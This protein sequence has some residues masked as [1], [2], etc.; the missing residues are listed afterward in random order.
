VSVAFRA[1]A[2][3]LER[4]LEPTHNTV[5]ALTRLCER[6][7]RNDDDADALQRAALFK[8]PA[9][10]EFHKASPELKSDM[11]RVFAQTLVDDVVKQMNGSIDSFIARIQ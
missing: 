8:S 3:M 2:Q 11:A 6:M 1:I 10:R 5:N 4:K 9:A 7:F